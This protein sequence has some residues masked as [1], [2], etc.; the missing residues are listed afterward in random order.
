MIRKAIDSDIPKIAK[1]YEELLKFEEQ[2]GTNSNWKLGIYPTIQVPQNQIPTGTMYVLEEHGDICASMVLNHKQAEEYSA[3]SWLYPAPENQVLVI[4]TLCIPPQKAGHG[5]G[6]QMIDYAKKYAVETRCF[7]IRI[8]TY[9]HNEPAKKLY[10]KNGFQISGYGTMC[11]QGFITEEQVYL[12][13]PIK[14]NFL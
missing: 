4:H 11:V 8:D 5:Y 2:N 9:A 6:T 3:V 13:C 10:Q 14:S 12:E 7:V 1:T